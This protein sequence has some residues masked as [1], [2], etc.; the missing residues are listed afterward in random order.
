[1]GIE[2]IILFDISDTLDAP[3]RPPQSIPYY[4]KGGTKLEEIE[5]MS[6]SLATFA[7]CRD[8]EEAEQSI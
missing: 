6:N 7:L 1:M 2:G 4:P 8:S 5:D 3:L